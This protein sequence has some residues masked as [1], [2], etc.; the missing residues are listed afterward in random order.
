MKIKYINI[1]PACRKCV[2]MVAVVNLLSFAVAMVTP[3]A[4]LKA[5][6]MFFKS[7]FLTAA[8]GGLCTGPAGSCLQRRCSVWALRSHRTWEVWR[9][10]QG[11]WSTASSTGNRQLPSLKGAA[12]R[13]PTLKESSPGAGM[14]SRTVGS[15]TRSSSWKTLLLG[16]ATIIPRR[17]TW[18]WAF[19]ESAL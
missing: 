14:V 11:G 10:V 1:V 5:E 9:S 12:A 13:S 2:K 7:L 15:W 3:E 18:S 8:S 16:A 17:P 4:V 6:V 19:L